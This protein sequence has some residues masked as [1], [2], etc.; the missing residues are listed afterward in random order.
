MKFPAA[1]LFCAFFVE[2]QGHS[3]ESLE[4]RMQQGR[5]HFMANCLI[6]HQVT[7]QGAPGVFPPLAKSDFLANDLKRGIRGVVEG[8][9]GP[10]TV[11]NRKYDGTMPPANLDDQQVADVFT[12]VLNSWGNAGGH[13]EPDQV[14]EIRSHSQYPTYEELV[15]ANTFAPLPTPPAGLELREIVRLPEHGIRLISNRSGDG[16]YLLGGT[17][18]IWR[19]DPTTTGLKQLL[20]G[21]NYLSHKGE[22]TSTW[23]VCLDRENRLYIVANRRDES[24]T[25]VTNEVTIY[26][27]TSI[28]EGDPAEPKAWFQAAYPWGVGPFNHCVNQCAIGPDGHLYV[29]SG[30]RSDGNEPGQDPHFWTGGEHPITACMWRLD[31][32]KEKPELEIYA[33]GLRNSFGFCWNDQGQLFATENGPDA[34]APEELNVIEKGKHYGF[35]YQFSDWTKKPYSYTPDPPTDLKFTRPV[36]NLGPDGGYNGHPIYTFDP[37]SSPAGIVF[38]K[39][40]FPPDY[41]GTFLVAR[42]GNLLKREKDVG[43]DV[44]QLRVRK[45]SSGG[46]EAQVKTVLAPLGRPIDLLANGKGKVYILEYSRPT[47]NIGSLGFPGRVLELSVKTQP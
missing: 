24:G 8:L 22:N 41:A 29:N 28:E 31:P 18:N 7:G 37:H 26:R 47:N 34:D 5:N 32:T 45:S 19:L 1:L 6:C 25:L 13:V 16:I 38:L 42:V 30:S 2:W 39:N 36:A 14:K 9:S 33:H 43:F 23:G 15:R 12:F 17:G 10:I 40:D 46:Y 27:T 20:W 4:M 21:K 35:P 44:L 3:A 11:N